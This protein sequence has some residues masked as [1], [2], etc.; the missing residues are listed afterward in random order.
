[1]QREFTE[2]NREHSAREDSDR[3]TVL[4]VVLKFKNGYRD[5]VPGHQSL[6]GIL[7]YDRMP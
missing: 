2:S 1:M 6:S 5:K 4:S 3:M 7:K